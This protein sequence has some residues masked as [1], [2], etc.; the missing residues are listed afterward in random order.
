[1]NLP[2]LKEITSYY[3]YYIEKSAEELNCASDPQEKPCVHDKITA[4]YRVQI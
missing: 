1:M 2:D 4:S 3:N